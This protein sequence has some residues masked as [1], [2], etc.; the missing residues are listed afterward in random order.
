MKILIGAPVRQSEEVF[1]EYLKSLDNLEKPCQVDRF[2]YLH[3]SP[4]LAK[5]LKP[6]EYMLATSKDE[7]KTDETTHHWKQA[8]LQIVT[9]FKNE[10]LKRTVEGGYDYFMLVDSDLILHPKTLISLL[11]ADKPIVAE[12]FWTRWQPE[13]E[14]MPNAWDLDQS[15]VFKDSHDR[16]KQPGI[17]RVGGTGAC[18]LIHRSVIE[19]GVNYN[20][21]YNLSLWG[22]DRGFCVRAVAMGYEIWLDTH[23]PAVHLYRKSELNKYIENGGYEAAFS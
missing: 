18:I 13:N 21:L 7:Y 9:Y 12:A 14:P 1:K 11:E 4:D 6:D 17:H 22:E 19:A 16:W 23:Y 3:N 5:H 15:S 2:F 10:L 8:N 20:M